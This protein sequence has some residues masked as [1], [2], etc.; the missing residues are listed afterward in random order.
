MN[1]K[2]QSS[3]KT[4]VFISNILSIIEKNLDN[5]VIKKS[6]RSLLDY[7]GVTLAGT[8]ALKEKFDKYMEF[9]NP[10]PGKI[11]AV[12]LNKKMT[13][14]DAVFFN[15]LNG[16]ALDFDDGTNMGIIHLGSPIFSVLLPIAQKYEIDS[17]KFF[18]AVVIGY[19]TSF[20]MAVSIQP[21]H[22]QLGYHATGTC[23]ILGIAM[24]VSYMLDFTQEEMMN[25]F[26]TACVSATGMLKV[27]DDGSELKP[28]NVAK[29]ALLGLISTEMARAGF[30]GHPDPLGGY[31]GY[32]KMMTGEENIELKEP[33]L[34]G[35][36][37]IEKTYTKPYAACRYC[38]PAIEA[39]I[40]IKKKY[41]IE[42]SQISLIDV[43]T[44]DL[45]VKGHDHTEALTTASAKMSIPYGVAAG[46]IFGKAG[47]KEY[48]PEV[49]KDEKMLK[50]MQK[51][52]VKADE[53][54]SRQFPKVTTAIV[55]VLTESGEQYTEQ[56]DYPKGEPENPMTD[57]EF[58]DRFIELAMYGGKTKDEAN[59]IIDIVEK[60]D[61][62]M[63]ALFEHI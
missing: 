47:L 12:G 10:E 2:E 51:V 37:A 55:R 5:E 31:R 40:N 28:Y 27:L 58:K 50:L 52:S 53:N 61:G 43:A 23:G 21:K 6:K 15:G 38:H 34:N 46:I 20:T 26:S 36:Y 11:T 35:T 30:Q 39:A 45:A 42:E 18:K 13:M 59:E 33:R 32:L 44:Y 60:M 8:T 7:I 19:E 24:A 54:I 1:P 29:T 49:L 63:E 17:E 4:K 48:E 16:H 22:K 57:D 56:V 9:S 3:N 41:N 14:K 62:D 25:A